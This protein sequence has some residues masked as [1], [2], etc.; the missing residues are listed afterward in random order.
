MQNRNYWTTQVGKTTLFRI[1]TKAH[2]EGKAGASATHVGVAKVRSCG[3]WSWRSCITRENYVRD[4]E[5]CDWVGCRR[6]ACGMRWRNC[7]KWM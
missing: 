3:W 4:S 1:L 6:N 7:A 5:L 2:V